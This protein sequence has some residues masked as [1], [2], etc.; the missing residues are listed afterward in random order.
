MKSRKV[1]LIEYVLM[2]IGLAAFALLLPILIPIELWLRYKENKE[3]KKR[4]LKNV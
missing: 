3:Q 1:G 4:M 2:G